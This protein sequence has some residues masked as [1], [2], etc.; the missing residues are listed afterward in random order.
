MA[1][2]KN[3]DLKSTSNPISPSLNKTNTQHDEKPSS[4]AN[5]ISSPV[6]SPGQST[7]SLKKTKSK[8]GTQEKSPRETDLPQKGNL[9]KSA[10]H[11]LTSFTRPPSPPPPPTQ[12]G[13]STKVKVKDVNPVNNQPGK[14]TKFTENLE[15]H[16]DVTSNEDLEYLQ[17]TNKART[18][19]Y[20]KK[21]EQFS[22]YNYQ[23][24]EEDEDDFEDVIFSEFF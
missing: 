17:K 12:E 2:G 18:Q 1:E 11:I 4:S 24:L 9:S 15:E 5:S 14:S 13:T 19:N 10:S 23:F 3:K 16:D 6:T 22:F 8:N 20:K 21:P 7:S